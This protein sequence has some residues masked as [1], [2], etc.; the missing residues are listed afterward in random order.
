MDGLHGAGFTR[1][2][3]ESIHC[4]QGFVRVLRYGG[5]VGDEEMLENLRI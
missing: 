4:S 3:T 1:P 2:Q 5:F